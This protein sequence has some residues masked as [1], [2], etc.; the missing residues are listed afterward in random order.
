MRR[1][2]NYISIASLAL[3]TGYFAQSLCTKAN[4]GD[5]HSAL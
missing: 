4:S 1:M 3:I 5:K 2:I